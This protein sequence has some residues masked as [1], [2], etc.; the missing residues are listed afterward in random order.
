MSA[1]LLTSAAAQPVRD[2]ALREIK[3][4]ATAPKVVAV[5]HPKF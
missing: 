4:L 3:Q 5:H 2:A 1:Q